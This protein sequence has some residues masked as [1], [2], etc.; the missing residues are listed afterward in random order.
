MVAKLLI[1]DGNPAWLSTSVVP[2]KDLVVS[3]S[4]SPTLA[5][6]HVTSTNVFVYVKVENTGNVDLGA[7]SCTALGAWAL[8][9]FFAGFGG[10][11]SFSTTVTQAGVT[12]K[13]SASGDSLNGPG[14]SQFFGISASGRRAWA[15]SPD[16]SFFAYV[17]SPNGNDWFLTIVA[18]QNVTRS[19]GATVAKGQIAASGNGVF[20]GPPNW[21]AQNFGWAGSRAVIASGAY[22]AG[23]GIARSLTCP[24]APPGASWGELAPSFPGQV[25]WA[26]LV[27]PCGAFVAFAPKRLTGSAPPQN[28]FLVSTATAQVVSFRKNNANT[29]VASTGASPSISTQAHS[30]NGVKI[31]TGNG[32]IV[33]VDDPECTFVGAGI[34][35]R[36]DRVKA[37][38]LPSANLGVVAVGTATLGQL[39][40][41]KSAWVQVP[42]VNGWDNQ[43]EAHWCLLGQT[44]TTDGTTIPRAWN[45]QLPMPP[46][47]PLSSDLCA[48]RNIEILP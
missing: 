14:I 32:S 30:A 2:S 10:S 45:G 27:S 8:P 39:A 7:C 42:N 3:P 13:A 40:A 19:N 25:D 29:S 18:L 48:Q 15:W 21:T 26:H 37:S 44:H 35:V 4:S 17:G 34:V 43:S 22:A 5:A 38:T 33:D 1:K 23:P 36:V 6:V 16:N 12:F 20:A 46:P 41:G 31:N 47:F 24:L 11:T 28:F 9:V